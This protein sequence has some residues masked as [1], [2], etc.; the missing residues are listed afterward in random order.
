MT[1][2]L[3]TSQH[4]G[5]SM[6]E[7]WLSLSEYSSKYGL[8]I[9]TL[10]RRIKSSN[11]EYR[12]ETGKYFILDE[13]PRKQKAI[14]T[15]ER[16]K[17]IPQTFVEEDSLAINIKPTSEIVTQ[18]DEKQI[19]NMKTAAEDAFSTAKELLDELKKSYAFILQEKEEQILYLKNEISDLRTLVRVL[20][21]DNGKLRTYIEHLHNVN[22]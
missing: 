7:N 19:Q 13:E 9:S 11:I 18:K 15:S 14:K 3:L 22:E 21:E 16:F 12:L 4:R 20:E 8:S 5:G 6:T 2:Q 17:S 10:R 1:T